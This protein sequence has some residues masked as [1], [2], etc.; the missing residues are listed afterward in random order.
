MSF[1]TTPSSFIRR[2]GIQAPL[3]VPT[4]LVARL[5]I[6]SHFQIHRAGTSAPR[7]PRLSIAS[8]NKAPLYPTARRHTACFSTTTMSSRGKKRTSSTAALSQ[9]RTQDDKDVNVPP[10]GTDYQ[11]ITAPEPRRSSRRTPGAATTT[12]PD[13]GTASFPH[14]SD[15]VDLKEKKGLSPKAGGKVLRK[16]IKGA[17][18]ATNDNMQSLEAL[19]LSF[20]RDLKRRK[21]QVETSVT[22]NLENPI[23]GVPHPRMKRGE[24]VTLPTDGLL[25]TPERDPETFVESGDAL[26]GIIEAERASNEELVEAADRGA[27]RPP[28]VNSTVLPLPWKG[29]LGYV[30]QYIPCSL[31]H[32]VS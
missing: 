12:G 20:K 21:L 32:T 28:A 8:A 10:S 14:L 4:L 3:P 31:F 9:L 1:P 17:Q 7:I 25:L 27:A 22:S 29:R 16:Q 23:V 13:K 26:E 15:I 24:S 18:D 5:A 2:V 6:P 11:D 30:G 19:E